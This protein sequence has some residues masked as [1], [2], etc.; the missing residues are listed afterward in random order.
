MG[1]YWWS[2]IDP[3]ACSS[4][5]LDPRYLYSSPYA[6]LALRG[7]VLSWVGSTLAEPGLQLVF[8]QG[9]RF[10]LVFFWKLFSWLQVRWLFWNHPETSAVLSALRRSVF[11]PCR[12]L[13]IGMQVD[14]DFHNLLPYSGH[15]LLPSQISAALSH[16]Q[17]NPWRPGENTRQNRWG[18]CVYTTYVYVWL[19]KLW[20]RTC[21]NIKG[22][23]ST[24]AQLLC[25][26][27]CSHAGM[28]RNW[29]TNVPTNLVISF[30]CH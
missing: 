11:F 23:P 12:V 22:S 2:G 10:Y 18:V 5:S 1:L 16:F 25:H 6:D 3:T 26:W 24:T 20:F 19:W 28:Y 15:N 9:C 29:G 27:V 4:S 7:S 21:H 14:C 17:G 30:F 13:C 8:L